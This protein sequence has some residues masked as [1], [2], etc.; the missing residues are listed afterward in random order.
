MKKRNTFKIKAEVWLYPGKAGWHFIT[1][2]KK[3]SDDILAIFGSLK[4]GW[5]SLPVKVTLGKSVWQTSIF[6]HKKSGGYL[7]PLKSDVRKKEKIVDGDVIQLSLVILVEF[8]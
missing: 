7:L 3:Q 2:P 8:D 4:R 6:P 1:I 5:G